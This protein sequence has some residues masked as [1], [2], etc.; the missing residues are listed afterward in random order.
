[1]LQ[2][3]YPSKVVNKFKLLSVNPENR[4]SPVGGFYSDSKYLIF[5]RFDKGKESVYIF[6]KKTKKIKYS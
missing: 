3:G 2:T 6:S 5:S 1:M 4:Y